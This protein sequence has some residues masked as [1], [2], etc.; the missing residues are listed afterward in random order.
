[1][2]PFFGKHCLF[3]DDFIL[4]VCTSHSIPTLGIR[5]V[6]ESDSHLMS[7]RYL[8]L[9]FTE[10]QKSQ[11]HDGATGEVRAA[12]KS[13][14]YLMHESWSQIPRQSTVKLLSYVS[15]DHWHCHPYSHDSSVATHVNNEAHTH[16]PAHCTIWQ[17]FWQSVF[18]LKKKESRKLTTQK[19]PSNVDQ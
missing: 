3:A 1:M 13:S 5:I 12:P 11:A 15:L 16:L 8:L 17:T 4:C 6:D 14:G 9:H 18:T 7:I 10:N 19:L 2:K